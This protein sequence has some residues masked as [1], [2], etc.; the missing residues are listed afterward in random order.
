MSG[1]MKVTKV[2]MIVLEMWSQ[3]SSIS[4]TKAF[5][6]NANSR[7]HLRPNE[8]K[9]LRQSAFLTSFPQHAL[10][11]RLSLLE[12]VPSQG[13]YLGFHFHLLSGCM[14]EAASP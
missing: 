9:I 13:T 2:K 14:W 1:Y 6:R 4:H 3:T 8:L 5:L 11:R 12:P 7:A 10:A